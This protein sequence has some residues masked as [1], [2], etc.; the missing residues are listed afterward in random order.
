MRRQALPSLAALACLLLGTG[1]A[2]AADEQT[3]AL[4]ER[5][6]QTITALAA[7]TRQFKLG[8]TAEDV[9]LSAQRMEL[10]YQSGR[11]VYSGR[12]RLRRGNATL[13]AAELLL[14]LGQGPGA[15]LRSAKATGGVLLTR[16]DETASGQEAA[17]D[18]AAGTITLEGNARLGSGNDSLVGERVIVH[19]GEGRTVVEGGKAP[20]RVRLDAGRMN[21]QGQ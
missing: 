16:G 12:V 6:G 5:A 1:A 13:E 17:Y 8:N 7:A 18:H 4:K 14:E 10:D 3:S 15:A 21:G 9:E 19:L 2:H 20:V 11:L